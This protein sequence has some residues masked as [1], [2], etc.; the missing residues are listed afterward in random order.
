MKSLRESDYDAEK[1]VNML[2]GENE[3]VQKGILVNFLTTGAIL[4]DLYVLFC[5]FHTHMVEP[6]ALVKQVALYTKL[7]NEDNIKI[8]NVERETLWQRALVFYK[9][10]PCKDLYK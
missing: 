3:N 2:L 1:A 7:V 4:V 5:S 10:T 8:I 9:A 6:N